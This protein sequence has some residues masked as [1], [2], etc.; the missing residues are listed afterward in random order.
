MFTGREHDVETGNYYYRARY[1]HPEIG[2]FLSPDPIA[3]IM[4][5]VS[6]RRR[7]EHVN[8]E[9]PGRSLSGRAVEEFLFT[10][11]IG[12]FLR[13]EPTSRALQASQYGL[14][15]ELNLYAYCGSNPANWIDPWGLISADHDKLCRLHYE[16]CKLVCHAH[17]VCDLNPVGWIYCMIKCYRDL[18]DCS[19]KGYPV[20]K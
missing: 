13:K 14:P 19:G 17:F 16:I 2:R 3:Q 18:V 12:E 15:I 20:S 7:A 5:I 9:I 11:P 1:Y 8:E 4:Q 6:T 10:Y